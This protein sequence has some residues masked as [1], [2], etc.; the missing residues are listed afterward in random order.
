MKE[1]R[2]KIDIKNYSSN[3]TFKSTTTLGT[4]GGVKG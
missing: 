1:K 2:D 3:T 4:S